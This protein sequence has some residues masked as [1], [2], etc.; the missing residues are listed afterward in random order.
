MKR[1]LVFAGLTYYPNGGWEDFNASYATE[2]EAI[3]V[4]KSLIKDGWNDWAHYIDLENPEK[5]R[6]EP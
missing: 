5:G 1:F 3:A 6:I 2:E 4:C